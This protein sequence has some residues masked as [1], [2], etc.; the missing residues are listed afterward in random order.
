M[1]T[2]NVYRVDYVKRERISIGTVVERREKKRP[3]NLVGLLSVARKAFA[4]TT[5]Q[6]AFQIVLEKNVLADL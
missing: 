2:F 3:G 6:S 1:H 5:P 4:L